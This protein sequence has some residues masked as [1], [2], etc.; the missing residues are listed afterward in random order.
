M[1]LSSG[2][3]LSTGVPWLR[4]GTAGCFLVRGRLPTL[5]ESAGQAQT[6]LGRLGGVL[7]SYVLVV[8]VCL[9]GCT[10]SFRMFYLLSLFILFMYAMLLWWLAI[11]LF[12]FLIYIYMCHVCAYLRVSIIK[13]YNTLFAVRKLRVR[14]F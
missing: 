7:P 12:L 14:A 11:D 8:S 2:R 13:R 5:G 6:V 3:L 4:E 9:F 1:P 10:S